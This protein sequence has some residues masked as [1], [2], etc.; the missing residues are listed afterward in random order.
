M[1]HLTLEYSE[2]LNST[3]LIGPLVARLAETMR[4][5]PDVFPLGGIR[6]R[7]ICTSLY[8]IADEK[9]ENAFVH[10]IL[11]IGAGRDEATKTSVCNEVFDTMKA[12]MSFEFD[13]RPLAL[14]LELTELP[15]KLSLKANSIHT[16][17]SRG[18]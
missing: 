12:H 2:N 3:G 6:V 8:S 9:P 4:R 18:V 14:S 10:G 15:E 5:R 13:A 17:L 1:P 16:R 11:K 7:A